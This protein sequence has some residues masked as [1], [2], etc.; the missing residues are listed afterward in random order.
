MRAGRRKVKDKLQD[1]TTRKV[2]GL[3][4]FLLQVRDGRH[5][6]LCCKREREVRPP[7]G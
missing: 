4:G 7:L 3:E 5:Q 1:V 6:K 2:L